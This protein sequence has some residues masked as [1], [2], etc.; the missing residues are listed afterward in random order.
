[1]SRARVRGWLAPLVS[2]VMWSAGAQAEAGQVTLSD[3]IRAAEDHPPRVQAAM[4][5]LARRSAET[6]V[7]MGAYYPTLT[8]QATNTFA[9]TLQPS[10]SQNGPFDLNST[11]NT[12]GGQLSADFQIFNRTRSTN[13]ASV[14]ATERSEQNGVAEVRRQAVQNAVELFVRALATYALIEDA[15]LTL[16]RRTQQY[17]AIQ[18]LVRAGL[19]PSVDETRA[20][21]EEVA[22]R[23][24]LEVRHVE[25]RAA[26]AALAVAVGRDPEDGMAPA[27]LAEDAFDAPT[28]TED[29]TRR[30]I[31]QRPDLRR[32]EALLEARQEDVKT[33]LARRLPVLGV[34]VAGS[35]SYIDRIEKWTKSF[36]SLALDE[37]GQ[38]QLNPDGTPRIEKRYYGIQGNAYNVSAVAYLRWTMLDATVIRSADVARG[39]MLEAQRAL[40][41]ATLELRGQVVDA[42]FAVERAKKELERAT[43]VL[44]AAA[45]TREAQLGRYKAGVASLLELLDAESLEQNARLT[46]IETSRDYDVARARLLAVVGALPGAR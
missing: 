35:A 39:A 16:D 44:G 12:V 13:A 37:N 8:G 27:P 34:T 24:R 3:V 2:V 14:K 40:E 18:G 28:S 25:Q 17:T 45:A 19:R 46:R 15:K 4:A 7:A 9:Y 21:V 31:A 1:M 11:S 20:Q 33:Q 29:A 5:T 38:P 26:F 30:A 6:S 43:E 36:P 32:L 42:V 22:A 41:V 23:Y 10:V